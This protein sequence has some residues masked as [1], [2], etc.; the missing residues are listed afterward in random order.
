VALTE[1]GIIPV[2]GLLSRTVRLADGQLA[3]YTTSGE[4]GPA[5]IL[6]HG[7]IVGSSGTAGWRFMAPFLGANGFRVYC[8]DQPGFGQADSREEY[9]PHLN[10]LS[11][12]NFVHNF[13]N[14]L[15]LDKFFLAGNSMGADNTIQY[16]MDHPE[17][18]IRFILIATANVGDNVADD[19]RVPSTLTNR[20]EYDGTP[21]GMRAVI[22]PI[23]YRKVALDPDLLEMRS[24]AA[25][26]Q[27][28]SNDALRAGRQLIR[29]DPSLRQR[30]STKDRFAKITIPGIYLYGQD[31]VLSPVGNGYNQ[32]DTLPNIQMFYPAECGHQGQT[33]QPDM[34]NQVFLEFFRDGKVSRKTADWAGISKRRPEL[35]HLVEQGAP[36][37]V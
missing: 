23:I 9:W 7:G 37:R 11:H 16:V 22:E 31:D 28:Q 33:D 19:K 25:N 32:E 27:K 17:R 10:T 34:F 8:P 35:A 24:R 12:A 29:E 6:L 30:W 20:A 1:E 36:A 26:N 18:V 5:V 21:E 14:A 3:H 15:G 4:S 13:A 2:P